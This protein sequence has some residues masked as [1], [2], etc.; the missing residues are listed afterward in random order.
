MLKEH[1]PP[2][3]PAPVQ[4][5]S[6]APR[7]GLASSVT[8]RSNTTRTRWLVSSSLCTTNRPEA[9]ASRA[10]AGP[11]APGLGIA[12]Y[13]IEDAETQPFLGLAAG[14]TSPSLVALAT[15]PDTQQLAARVDALEALVL[16]LQPAQLPTV[17]API[18]TVPAAATAV[19]VAPVPK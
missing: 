8:S 7:R 4:P 11:A 3:I 6:T 2:S 12:E 17:A 1:E 16:E 9:L 10:R 18:E 19:P 15:S 5:G 14:T 13:I